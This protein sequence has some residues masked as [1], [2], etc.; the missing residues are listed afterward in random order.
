MKKRTETKNMLHFLHRTSMYIHP[1]YRD[2][3][4]AFMHGVDFGKYDK[5]ESWCTHLTTFISSKYEIFGG[6]LGWP[7]QIEIYAKK[8]K[9]DWVEA[10][11]ILMLQLIEESD[12]IPY[13]KSLKV[14]NLQLEEHNKALKMKY[15]K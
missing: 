9:I 2:T 14:I 8:Y 3:V 1:I 7:N 4:V 11:K 12:Q 5:M 15:A 13:T 6:A 10:F